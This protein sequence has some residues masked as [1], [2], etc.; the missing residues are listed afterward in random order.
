MRPSPAAALLAAASWWAIA[1]PAAADSIPSSL[2]LAVST[3]AGF[4][5]DGVGLRLDLRWGRGGLFFSTGPLAF[6]RT[7]GDI[8]VAHETPLLGSWA[9]GVRWFLREEG[10]GPWLSACAMRS[11]DRLTSPFVPGHPLERSVHAAATVGWRWRWGGF[12][13]EAGAG[14]V[15]H[16]D[17][18]YLASEPGDP[19]TASVATNV[20][21]L[22]DSARSGS[23]LWFIPAVDAGLGFEF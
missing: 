21:L 11:E 16:Y 18:Q 10:S 15:F 17:R 20:G 2:H 7:R 8:T 13:L 22:Y 5:Y 23:G 1:R 14:P 3:G 4:A 12:F 6:P 19:K 9:A